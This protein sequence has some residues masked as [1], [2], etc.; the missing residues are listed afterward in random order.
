LNPTLAMVAGSPI[1]RHDVDSVLATA[2][3][4]IREDYLADPEQYKML[5]NRIVQQQI[6]YLAAKS[7][8]IESD[9]AYR[10]DLATQQRQLIMKHYYAKAVGGLPAIPDSAVRNYYDTHPSEFAM[11]GRARVRHIQVATRARALE[12]RKRLLT[13]SWETAC[14]RYSTDKVTAKS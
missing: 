12:V 7:A 13:T 10:L 3:A 1:T 9:S 4:S 11:P 8:G 14:A 6:I 2:P 5:V